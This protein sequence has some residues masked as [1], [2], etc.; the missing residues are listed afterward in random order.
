VKP[1]HPQS[2]WRR[3]DN[4]TT[5]LSPVSPADT[6]SPCATSPLAE[7][8]AEATEKEEADGMALATGTHEQVAVATCAQRGGRWRGAVHRTGGE[9]SEER[10]AGTGVG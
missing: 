9:E 2:E 3:A 6:R 5:L 1:P 10:A 7:A 4:P 8:D